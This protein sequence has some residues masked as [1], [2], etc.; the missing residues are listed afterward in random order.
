MNRAFSGNFFGPSSPYLRHPLLTAERTA[1]EVDQLVPLLGLNPG[2]S[3]LD[4]GCGFGRHS[5]ELAGR[6]LAVTAIDPSPAMI[7]AAGAAAESAG[8]SVEFAVQG[9]EELADR[10]SFDGAI[11]MFTTLGQ[12]RSGTEDNRALLNRV[13]VALRPGSRFLVEVPQREAT[14]AALVG[15]E[16]FG[17]GS[18]GTEIARSYNADTASVTESFQ[19]MTDGRRQRFDLRYRLFSAGELTDL[20]VDAGFV[21]VRVSGSLTGLAKATAQRRRR[22]DP[23]IFALGTA[24]P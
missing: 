14:V 16:R 2:A 10:Q 23:T 1:A 11:C 7:A 21:D 20:L 9:G 12:I 17:D 3:V 8:R 15:S 6:G 13:A 19:V 22:G 4:V 5:L 24:R 18:S